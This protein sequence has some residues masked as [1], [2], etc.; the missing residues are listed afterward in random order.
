VAHESSY[1]DTWKGQTL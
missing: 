1:T